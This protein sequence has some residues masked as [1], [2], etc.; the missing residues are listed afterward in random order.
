IFA[1]FAGSIRVHDKAIVPPDSADA[2]PLW[3]AVAGEKVTRA[4]KFLQ[5]LFESNDGR[6]AYLYDTIG[7]L[8]PPRRAFA[9]GLWLPAGAPRVDR[10]KQLATAGM[11]A[12][13]EWHTRILP[14]GRSSFDLG[15]ILT[16][17]AV[18][19]HG[20]PRPPAS[21]GLLARALGGPD[22]SS[23]DPIDAA[24]LAENILA[25]DV[26]Q[27]GDRVDLIT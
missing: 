18:D 6:L 15:M 21:R 26:R 10:F 27:R 7:Q 13:R 12:M 3:E 17:L 1:A 4:D 5:V 22:S 14:F 2:I 11:N 23:D 16:R 9:L 25:T 20:A 24:W 8:D 19:E